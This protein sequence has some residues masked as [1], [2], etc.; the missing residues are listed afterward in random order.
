MSR[1]TLVRCD[2]CK[3]ERENKLKVIE[4]W[5]EQGLDL[6]FCSIDCI[7]AYH[8]KLKENNKVIIAKKKLD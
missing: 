2:Y 1:K 6:D 3:K 4:T 8:K 5:F 7:I